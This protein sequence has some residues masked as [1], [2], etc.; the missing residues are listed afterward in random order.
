MTLETSD[1]KTVKGTTCRKA[2]PGQADFHTV[3]QP[4]ITK[5]QSHQPTSASEEN[6]SDYAPNA[7]NTSSQTQLTGAKYETPPSRMSTHQQPL[8]SE[9]TLPSRLTT[10]R[11]APLNIRSTYVGNGRRR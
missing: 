7:S 9:M 6:L 11:P 3:A 1:L 10:A 8:D 4:Q 2:S 5:A